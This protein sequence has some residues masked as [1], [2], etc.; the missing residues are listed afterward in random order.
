MRPSL[1]RAL[2][3]GVSLCLLAAHPARAE[4]TEGRR[5]ADDVRR[6]PTHEIPLVPLVTPPPPS[7]RLGQYGLEESDAS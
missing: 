2:G 3:L 5:P 6:A 1:R 4:E 7:H